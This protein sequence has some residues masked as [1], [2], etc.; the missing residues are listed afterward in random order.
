MPNDETG[1]TGA[2]G[3]PPGAPAAGSGAMT[4]TETR[5]RRIAGRKAPYDG[6]IVAIGR[7]WVSRDGR[8]HAFAARF[9]DYAVLTPDHLVLCSTGFFSRRPR[10]RVFREPL[11]RLDVV[12]LGGEPVHTVR[13]D[14]N[15]SHAIRLELRPNEAG[16]TFARELLAATRKIAPSD[17]TRAIEVEPQ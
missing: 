4:H 5:L 17:P 7:A 16:I 6:P 11:G 14:G 13:V 10:R 9:L 2:S 1:D 12:A 3:E 8:L 15:F